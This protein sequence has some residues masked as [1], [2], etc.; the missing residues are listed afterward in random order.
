MN[1]YCCYCMLLCVSLLMSCQSGL[2]GTANPEGQCTVTF[3]V[4]N[5]RQISF[6][7]LLT[8]ATSRA[9]A[10]DH[11]ATLAH[12]LIAVYDEETG[13][14]VSFVRHDQKDY[15]KQNDVYPKFSVTLPYG[16]YRILALGFNGSREC[17]IASLNHISWQDNY[18]PNTFLYCNGF[19]LDKNTNPDQQIT[20]RHVVTAFRIET[21][22]AIPSELK[23]MRFSSSVGGTVLDAT[24]GFTSQDVGRT[25]EIVVPADSVGKPGMF[26]SYLFLSEEQSTSNYTVQ[27]LGQG[28]KV[29]YEKRFKDVP[30]HINV[31]T[32]WQGRFFEETSSS[33]V[34]A[35]D[36][37]VNL[38]WDTKW[39]DVITLDP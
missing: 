25:S 7:D 39:A 6:D 19:T 12:L 35:Y 15:T 29:L 32:Q 30:L 23:K 24:T 9:V 2:D 37:G 11:P 18:V 28:D 21:E 1:R 5:Y 13:K 14:Q 16:Q 8:S 34:E 4:S 27:A 36:T 33:D 22:D 10:S 3:S 20:L 38:Y 26:T 31:L 17:E